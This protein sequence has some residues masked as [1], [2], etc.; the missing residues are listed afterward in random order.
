MRR[1]IKMEQI[2]FNHTPLDFYRAFLN[3]KYFYF[4]S[5]PIKPEFLDMDSNWDDKIVLKRELQKHNVPVPAFL[6][7]PIF[8]LKN[9][10]DIFSQL[11]APVIVKPKIGS[12]ARHTVTNINTKEQFKKG[13]ELARQISAYIVAEEHIDGY[14][15]RATVVDGKL[16]GFYRGSIP[17]ITGDGQKTIHDLIQI[18][19]GEREE[20]YSIRVSE[21]LHDHI[22]RAGFKIDDVLPE[23]VSISLSHRGGQL[24][25]GNTKEMIDD[26]HPS[27]IPVF[28]RAASA[29][30]LAVAGFDAIIPDPT[31]D[32]SSQKWGIIEC[33]TLPFIDVHYFALEGKPR[34][35]A[36]MVWDMWK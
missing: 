24:F 26:L 12:R 25:G 14:I 32:A 16:G 18:R 29:V 30:G 3:G 34:N 9:L 6:H 20:R 1:G 35:I 15:C 28:E 10:D 17:T 5:I 8:N 19:N 13:V 2:I 23:G 22:E 33:N 21:E 11:E 4:E 7:L 36:G 31:K 27:F